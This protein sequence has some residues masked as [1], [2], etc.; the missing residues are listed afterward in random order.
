M[1]NDEGKPFFKVMVADMHASLGSTC[2]PSVGAAGSASGDEAGSLFR[3]WLE[4]NSMAA[5]NMFNDEGFT[6]KAH[7]L[8]YIAVPCSW[9]E[10]A[11]EVG[12]RYDVDISTAARDDHFLLAARLLAGIADVCADAREAAKEKQKQNHDKYVFSQALAEAETVLA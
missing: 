6:R 5:V 10:I 7:R 3:N 12:P 4:P 1:E 9:L 11:D 8:D 2:S